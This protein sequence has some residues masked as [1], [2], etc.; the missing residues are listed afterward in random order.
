MHW[1][2]YVECCRELEKDQEKLRREREYYHKMAGNVKDGI[3]TMRYV[4]YKPGEKKRRKSPIK[5]KW[6]QLWKK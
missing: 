2:A 1:Q 6:W 3:V 4:P 5:N